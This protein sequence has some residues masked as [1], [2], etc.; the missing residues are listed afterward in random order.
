MKRL[1]TVFALLALGLSVQA[2]TVILQTTN[3]TATPA[4][5]WIR[6]TWTGPSIYGSNVV[7]S[8]ASQIYYPV[9][10]QAP[11]APFLPG[12]Y[13]LAV[14]NVTFASPVLFAVPNDTNTYYVSQLITNLTTTTGAIG[15]PFV[16]SVTGAGSVAVSPASGTGNVTITGLNP[17]NTPFAIAFIPDSQNIMTD[18]NTNRWVQTMNWCSTN[19]VIAMV[20][21]EGDIVN[22]FNAQNE[23]NVAL[24][25][26][27]ACTNKPLIAAAGNHDMDSMTTRDC[28]TFNTLE[29]TPSFYANRA[30]NYFFMTNGYQQNLYTTITNSG[31]KIVVVSLMFEPTTNEVQWASNVF[32]A[33]PDHLA[34]FETHNYLLMD[35]TQ[36]EPGDQYSSTGYGITNGCDGNAIWALLKGCRNLRF[37]V[38]GHQICAPQEAHSQMTGDAGNVV[39]QVFCNYQCISDGTGKFVS[40]LKILTFY[41]DRNEVTAQ[42]FDAGNLAW[43]PDT[44]TYRL[45][46]VNN[47]TTPF[48]WVT[49]GA[50][51]SITTNREH[52]VVVSSTVTNGTSYVTNATLAGYSAANVTPIDSGLIF[53]AAM[54]EGSGTN[55]LDSSAYHAADTNF[56]GSPV[57]SSQGFLNSA[58]YETGTNQVYWVPL[59]MQTV[60]NKFSLSLWFY[61][62]GTP[63]WQEI[64]LSRHAGGT[65]G[66]FFIGAGRTSASLLNYTLIAAGTR[67]NLDSSVSFGLNGWH[68]LAMT[69][70]GTNVIGYYDGTN[71]ASGAL[72]G[73]LAYTFGSADYPIELGNYNGPFVPPGSGFPGTNV[74]LDEIKIYNR[75]LSPAEVWRSVHINN[76]LVANSLVTN[77][78]NAN[79]VIGTN[80]AAFGTT[81]ATNAVVVIGP[82]GANRGSLDLL[83]G[84]S[85]GDQV[86]FGWSGNTT[87]GSYIHRITT[88]HNGSSTTG[89]MI[90]FW[91]WNF[92]VDAITAP[93]SLDLLNLRGDGRVGI[94][95]ALPGYT[96]DVNGSLGVESSATFNTVGGV[97][98]NNNG[99]SNIPLQVN[100]TGVPG[101]PVLQTQISGSPNF[102]TDDTGIKVWGSAVLSATPTTPPSVSGNDV[103]LWNSNKVIY[104]VSATKTVLIIDAR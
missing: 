90:R 102:E 34:I 20:C 68:Q 43:L 61:K 11:R 3:W 48:T 101:V 73:N 80:N 70:D 82:S 65:A 54:D 55:L 62:T 64:W 88:D 29:I 23:W 67:V 41:P 39:N 83:N 81:P 93:G 86:Q 63:Q 96:L 27:A 58:L 98:I 24:T 9:N 36:V 91:M 5:G 69:Y 92:G 51:I 56:L 8:P 46:L 13:S 16:T 52:Q 12:L 2:S 66:D 57:W 89:N 40:Y 76:N 78:M 75:C 60:S 4:T 30:G 47:T 49:N 17:T 50:G 15:P 84:G 6:T 31:V 35:G 10:G 71:V 32:A 38:C 53:Y 28:T 22:T 97:S 1:F 104:A 26:F 37:V 100:R 74:W 95:T 19:P 99:G 42:T 7:V 72:S 33:Y 21:G 44:N 85:L 79:T 25:G 103:A 94:M 77:S 18:G 59:A 14:Q 87:Y 45:P